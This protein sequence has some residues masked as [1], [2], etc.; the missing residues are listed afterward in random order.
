[1]SDQ[2]EKGFTIKDRRRF[3]ED[4]KPRE[5]ADP[6]QPAEEAKDTT[7]R[8]EAS[9][10][11][12]TSD[13]GQPAA[14]KRE[15]RREEKRQQ[16]Q[17]RMPREID[18]S[19]FILSLSSSAMYHMGLV[20]IPDAPQPE[21]NLPLAKQTVDILGMLRNKTAGNLT[22]DEEKLLEQLLYDL[23]MHFVELTRQKPPV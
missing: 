13:S 20:Q 3:D 10:A 6:G 17:P 23:R 15:E 4:G 19:T 14:E 9:E 12:E 18:F 5:T 1:M 16:S 7:A 11:S 21:V 8:S 22:G 2:E